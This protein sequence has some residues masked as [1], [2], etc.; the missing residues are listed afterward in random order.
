MTQIGPYQGSGVSPSSYNNQQYGANGNSSGIQSNQYDPYANQPLIG[1]MQ[2]GGGGYGPSPYGGAYGGGYGYGTN[3]PDLHNA[4]NLDPLSYQVYS[5]YETQPYIVPNT[6]PGM[7][8]GGQYPPNP[9]GMPPQGMAPQ[10]ALPPSF[11]D[12]SPA[13]FAANVIDPMMGEASATYQQ[14]AAMIDDYEKNKKK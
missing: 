13:G 1:P 11:I 5:G 10:Q 4:L 14:T 6:Q 2:G 12:D 7:Q 9:N 8:G 3:S